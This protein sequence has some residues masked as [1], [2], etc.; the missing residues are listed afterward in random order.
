MSDI[1]D[2]LI[3]ELYDSLYLL[4]VFLVIGIGYWWFNREVTPKYQTR[5]PQPVT[6]KVPVAGKPKETAKAS[7][8]ISIML[9][10]RDL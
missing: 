3:Q 10:Y 8:V 6:T 1:Y 5:L 2:A 7:E 4:P 9:I